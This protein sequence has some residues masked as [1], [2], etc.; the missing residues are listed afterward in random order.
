[1]CWRAPTVCSARTAKGGLHMRRRSNAADDV[2]AVKQAEAV[3]R[4]AFSC[5]VWDVDR[6]VGRF[7]G[8]NGGDIQ[9]P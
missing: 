2:D 8:R 9:R 4:D 6:L 3:P 7:D 5:E 1:M